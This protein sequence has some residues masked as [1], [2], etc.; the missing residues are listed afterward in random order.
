MWL[1]LVRKNRVKWLGGMGRE[2]RGSGLETVFKPIIARDFIFSLKCTKKCLAAGLRP[3]PLGELKRSPR[4]PIA[5][6]DAMEG[7]HS[8]AVRVSLRRGRG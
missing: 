3:D 6:V 7:K 2:N 5:A 8:S 1:V 4:P